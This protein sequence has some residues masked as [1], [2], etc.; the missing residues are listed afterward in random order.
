[1]NNNMRIL[2]DGSER[3]KL[4]RNNHHTHRVGDLGIGTF[5]VLFF[6]VCYLCT[7]C[8]GLFVRRPCLI[9]IISTFSYGTI[10]LLLFRAENVSDWNIESDDDDINNNM[11]YGR[12]FIRVFL[13]VSCCF[14]CICLASLHLT[15]NTHANEPEVIANER[16]TSRPVF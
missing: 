9:Y 8:A 13:I 6:G 16:S 15:Q 1:M 7:C 4:L 14:G 5:L 3:L 10:L 2:Q 11:W 12:F